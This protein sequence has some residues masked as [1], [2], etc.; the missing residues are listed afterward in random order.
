M[1]HTILSES[2]LEH[3]EIMTFKIINAAYIE[4]T[5]SSGN[6]YL[7]CA[8][9]YAYQE[10]LGNK[11]QGDKDEGLYARVKKS[12][13]SFIKEQR[14]L[15]GADLIEIANGEFLDLK[16]KSVINMPVYCFYSIN[17]FDTGV[18]YFDEPGETPKIRYRT[19]KFTIPKKVFQDF[20]AENFGIMN[21]LNHT[22]L[23]NRIEKSLKSEGCK[24]IL[25]T[26]IEYVS[27]NGI[28]WVCPENHPAELFYK[29][30]SFS[31]QKEGRIVATDSAISFINEKFSDKKYRV[32]NIG[33]VKEIVQKNAIK[34]QDVRVE[35][36]RQRIAEI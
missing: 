28:E 17:A 1:L 32:L 12:N 3:A 5:I 6:I 10:I 7:G 25:K 18:K 36:P 4:T 27:R 23:Y 30:D 21:F 35:I 31:Y 26:R 13:F 8:E 24:H 14:E 33:D 22:D 15:H 11:G 29:D 19:Y 20:S 16:L 2:E 34:I 9:Y